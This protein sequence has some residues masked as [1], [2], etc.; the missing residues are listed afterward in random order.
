MVFGFALR[1]PLHYSPNSLNL[2]IVMILVS[3]LLRK[4]SDALM[5]MINAFNSSPSFP[6]APS[7]LKDTSF[8]LV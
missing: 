7:L 5:L 3:Q 6:L 4:S 2:G 8:F 1:I